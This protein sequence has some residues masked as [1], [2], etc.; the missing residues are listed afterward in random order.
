MVEYMGKVAHLGEELPKSLIMYWKNKRTWSTILFGG[1][2]FI[3]GRKTS[4]MG[5]MMLTQHHRRVLQLTNSLKNSVNW[6]R[7]SSP[8]A[9]KW[10]VLVS[11]LQSMI[12][13]WWNPTWQSIS[14]WKRNTCSRLKGITST[15]VWPIWQ[16]Q[17]S[18]YYIILVI[19]HQLSKFL[20]SLRCEREQRI[21]FL[22]VVSWSN[23]ARTCFSSTKSF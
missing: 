9:S 12:W 16:S 1:R 5:A 17:I 11:S 13:I 22:R 14:R 7:S 4:L 3:M 10:L 21:F 6:K 20:K 18:R 8:T 2:G 23:Q 19:L 15:R